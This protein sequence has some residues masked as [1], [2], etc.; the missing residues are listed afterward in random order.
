MQENRKD[1][2][3]ETNLRIVYEPQPRVSLESRRSRLSSMITYRFQRR[4]VVGGGTA[5]PLEY[6]NNMDSHRRIALNN[7]PLPSTLGSSHVARGG[8]RARGTGLRPGRAPRVTK[9]AKAGRRAFISKVFSTVEPTRQSTDT[10][11]TPLRINISRRAVRARSAQMMSCG[12][13]GP[14]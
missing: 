2:K 5:A 11:R 7:R 10:A 3:N 4:A 1:P 14:D 6:R 13:H 9:A 12:P 8:A